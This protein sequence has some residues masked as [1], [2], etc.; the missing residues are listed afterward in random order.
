MEKELRR[1]DADIKRVTELD[2]ALR[3]VAEAACISREDIAEAINV[4][5]AA[6]ISREDIFDSQGPPPVNGE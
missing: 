4:E 5:E 6:G 2:K 1:L 3:A